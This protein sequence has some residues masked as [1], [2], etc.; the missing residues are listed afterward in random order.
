MRFYRP[1]GLIVESLSTLVDGNG[2]EYVKMIVRNFIEHNHA[3]TAFMQSSSFNF[4]SFGLNGFSKSAA[5]PPKITA[6][7]KPPSREA[8]CVEPEPTSKEQA[9]VYRLSGYVPN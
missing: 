4:G 8:D 7:P 6:S 3:L 2:T 5:E 9:L 1:K